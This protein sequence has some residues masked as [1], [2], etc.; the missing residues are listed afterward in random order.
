MGNYKYIDKYKSKSGKWIYVYSKTGKSI[1]PNKDKSNLTS[2][3]KGSSN[4]KILDLNRLV[5]KNRILKNIMV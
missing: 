5:T 3:N 1:T 2:T 4:K